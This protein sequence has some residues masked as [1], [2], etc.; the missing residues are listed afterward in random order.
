MCIQDIK[1]LFSEEEFREI[2]EAKI[3]NY[4]IKNNYKEYCMCSNC[5]QIFKENIGNRIADCSFCGS[6]IILHGEN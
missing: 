6:E 4:V 1:I 2:C 5:G 3:K